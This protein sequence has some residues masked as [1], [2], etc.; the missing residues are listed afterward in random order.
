MIK[1]DSIQN[2]DEG[3]SP[4]SPLQCHQYLIRKKEEKE[5]VI[6][7][8]SL[9]LAKST[10]KEIPISVAKPIILRY[11]WLGKMPGFSCLAYGHYF[12][13][14]LGGVV[15][16]GHTTG[17]N[18]AFTKL[19]PNKKVIVLQRGV[20]LWWTPKN[21]A[22]WFISKVCK[23]LSKKGY[24]IITATADEEAGEVGTIYQAL[25]W[26]YLGS[27]KHGHP[28]FIIDGKETHPKTL[29]DKH[30]TSS[31]KKIQEI[32]GERVII[33]KRI[34]KHRYVFSLKKEIK[35][36][37]LPYIKREKENNLES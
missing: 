2:Q 11:E 22:S 7:S 1:H 19:F 10:I 37:S 31:V 12:E 34:F 20:H 14:E 15:L 24:D 32:Y 16:L 13:E 18:N 36:N 6:P 4:I 27:M 17:S 33:K 23:I 8:V 28:V 35:I 5:G 9:E 29:Y 25:N 26:K 3:S 30:G 21:S